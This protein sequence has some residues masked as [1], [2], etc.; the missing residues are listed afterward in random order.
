MSALR[1]AAS[2]GLVLKPLT[3]DVQVF[4]PPIALKWLSMISTSCC[5]DPPRAQPKL[6]NRNSLAGGIGWG[7]IESYVRSAAHSASF[8]V[9]KSVCFFAVV[10]PVGAAIGGAIY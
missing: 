6:S 7:E 3:N 1:N 10:D 8:Q 2:T 5:C 4:L 9:T